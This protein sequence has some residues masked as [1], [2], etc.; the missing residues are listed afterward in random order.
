MQVLLDLEF[1]VIESEKDMVLHSS[2]NIIVLMR[3]QN[4]KEINLGNY[5]NLGE[6]AQVLDAKHAWQFRWLN[7]IVESSKIDWRAQWWSVR[8]MFWLLSS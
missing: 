2:A 6:W 5:S 8:T 7:P 4:K 3:E 1:G